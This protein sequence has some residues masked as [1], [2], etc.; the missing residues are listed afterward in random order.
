VVR[1]YA[2]ALKIERLLPD[3]TACE[4]MLE[5][6]NPEHPRRDWRRGLMFRDVLTERDVRA[7]MS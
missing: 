3:E 7:V 2:D 1:S 4:E 5:I 6:A